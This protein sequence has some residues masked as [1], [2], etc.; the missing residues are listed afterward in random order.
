MFYEDEYRCD[1]G[2]WLISRS[3]VVP[4]FRCDVEVGYT[5]QRMV[6]LPED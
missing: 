4:I 6:G 5:K 3:T 2:K 1:N